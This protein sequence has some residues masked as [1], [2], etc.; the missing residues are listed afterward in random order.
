MAMLV[1]GTLLA[2]DDTDSP[3]GM[4][5]TYLAAL[6][7]EELSDYDLIGLPRLVRLNPNVPWKTRGNAAICLSMGEGSGRPRVCGSV[8]WGPLRCF[9]SGK[10]ADAAELVHRASKVLERVA[11]F[12]CDMTNPGI[13]ASNRKPPPS[14]YWRAVREVVPLSEVEGMLDHSGAVW[15]KYKTGRGIIGA[16]A[17]MSWRPRDRTWEVIAYR[18]PDLIGTPRDIDAKSVIRMDKATRLTF[19]NY[20]YENGHIAIAPGSPCPILFGIRGDSA[21]ELLKARTM[22]KGEKAD[23]WLLFLTNQATE[24]HIVDRRIADLRPR[25]S[26]RVRV[27]VVS[28]PVTIPGAH[29]ILRVSD[30]A[31]IDAAFYEPSRAFRDV[32]RALLPGDTLT[33]YG[34]VRT[35]PRSLNVEKMHVRKLVEDV[36]KVHNPVCKTCG[37]S[38]GSMGTGQGYRCKKC[39]AKA[40]AEAAEFRAFPRAVRPGWYEPPVASRRHL[41]KPIRRMSRVDVDNL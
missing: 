39:G 31:E 1:P 3:E 38:M 32:A 34:S 23:K 29:V 2:F 14:L 40:L 28:P 25:D 11:R 9:P 7:I 20:D 12:D 4:C 19:N 13:V 5:T 8:G 27:R 33:L 16:A 17:A 21:E 30:G 24:D 6:V 15:K 36:R 41:H 37:K 22:I 35:S 10:P 18:S 26:A